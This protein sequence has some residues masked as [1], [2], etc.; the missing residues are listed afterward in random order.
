MVCSRNKLLHEACKLPDSH[1][2]YF[3]AM[4]DLTPETI[5]SPIFISAADY[6]TIYEQEK[7]LPKTT[8]RSIK[9]NWRNERIATL[10]RTVFYN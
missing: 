10:P 7:A 8:K 9:T 1:L 2:F 3:A 4:T 6:K 5:L